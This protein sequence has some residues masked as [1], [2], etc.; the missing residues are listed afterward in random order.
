MS[1][2]PGILQLKHGSSWDLGR[3]GMT[4]IVDGDGNKIWCNKQGQ[5]HRTDGPAVIGADGGQEWWVNHQLHRTDGP[6]VVRAD[7]YQAWW[8]NHQLHRTDGPARI[9]ANGDQEWYINHQDITNEVKAW[10]ET[11]DVTWP[12]DSSTQ[13]LFVLTFGV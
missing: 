5:L 6:A 8:V 7:G 4:C 13:I 9:W 3:N 1:L 12:W 2:S 11:Q 10:M